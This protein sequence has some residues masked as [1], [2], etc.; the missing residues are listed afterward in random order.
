MASGREPA[1][2]IHSNKQFCL[3]Q[4]EQVMGAASGATEPAPAGRASPVR[5]RGGRERRGL[6]FT[7]AFPDT[8]DSGG[9]L[10]LT[11]NGWSLLWLEFWN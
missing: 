9:M 6:V 3:T 4:L 10:G 5:E 2:A 8:R 7:E 11:E 1:R